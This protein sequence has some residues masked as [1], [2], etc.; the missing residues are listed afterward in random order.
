MDYIKA[1]SMVLTGVLRMYPINEDLNRQHAPLSSKYSFEIVDH[2]LNRLCRLGV[3]LK[4][5]VLQPDLDLL[6]F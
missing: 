1:V 2:D 6:I 3:E 5:I 4:S